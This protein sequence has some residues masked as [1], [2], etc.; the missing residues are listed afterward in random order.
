MVY[1][2]LKT[3]IL[4]AS[5]KKERWE[6]SDEAARYAKIQPIPGLFYA[7]MNLMNSIVDMY[8]LGGGSAALDCTIQVTAFQGLPAVPA[9]PFQRI[10]YVLSVSSQILTGHLH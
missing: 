9:E 10:S 3:V 7:P 6:S 1:G 4:I 8:G 2:H 5:V